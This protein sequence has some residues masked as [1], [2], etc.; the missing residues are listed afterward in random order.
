MS[1]KFVFW[2]YGHGGSAE[3]AASCA[4]SMA[5]TDPGRV[6]LFNEE[7]AGS[8]VETGFFRRENGQA[9]S[10]GT[11][12]ETGREALIRLATN[13]RLSKVN[14]IDYTYP[15][16]KGR[17]DLVRGGRCSERADPAPEADKL[18]L[19]Y[20]VA[21]QVYDWIFTRSISKPVSNPALGSC[22]PREIRIAVLRQNRSEL[23]RFFEDSAVAAEEGRPRLA[24]LILLDH[25]DPQ[26]HWSAGN[27]RRRYNFAV[28]LYTVPYST[29]FRDAWNNAEIL[30]NVR[31]QRLTAK[32]LSGVF[33]ICHGLRELVHGKSSGNRYGKGA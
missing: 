24:D 7:E 25:F 2:D 5:L 9:L 30:R 33:K 3:M 10:P 22:Q 32:K 8:G 4:V 27:I 11:M 13:K 28:P 21:G 29:A 14:F 23:E 6:L 26:S 12:T 16:L 18:D 31:L 19:V 1:S 20:L 15:V 17:L